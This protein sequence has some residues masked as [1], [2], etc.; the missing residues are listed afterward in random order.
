M[1]QDTLGLH[2]EVYLRLKDHNLILP[3]NLFCNLITLYNGIYGPVPVLFSFKLLFLFFWLYFVDINVVCKLCR[4]LASVRDTLFS[5]NIRTVYKI[6][7]LKVEII[8]K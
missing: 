2:S 5:G 1:L 7:G 8:K 6:S 3:F 4:N